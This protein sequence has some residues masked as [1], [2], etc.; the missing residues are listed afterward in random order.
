MNTG[1]QLGG[2]NPILCANLLRVVDQKLLELLR[3]LSVEEWDVQTVAPRWRVRVLA[4][5]LLDTALRKLSLVRDSCFAWRMFTKGIPPDS[6]LEQVKI[7]GTKLWLPAFFSSQR[8]WGEAAIG[9][10]AATRG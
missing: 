4:A 2:Y 7:R 8:S 9:H 3:S 1:I 6:A 10:G 5:H